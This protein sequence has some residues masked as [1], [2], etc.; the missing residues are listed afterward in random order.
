M[1]LWRRGRARAK[2]AQP[3][4]ED[5]LADGLVTGIVFRTRPRRSIGWCGVGPAVT[6]AASR[7]S[8]EQDPGPT[9]PGHDGE[10]PR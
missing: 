2:V 6:P 8:E 7:T 1:D 10:D 4:A 3:A 5:T 9:G